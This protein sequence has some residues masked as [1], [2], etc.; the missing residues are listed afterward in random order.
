MKAVIWALRLLLFFVLFGFATKNDH[1]V[2]LHFFFDAHWELPLVF[3]ILLAFIAGTLIG[4]SAALVSWLSHQRE[5]RRLRRELS[6]ERDKR[7]DLAESRSVP[8]TRP[9]S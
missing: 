5:V 2:S 9:P 8:G 6:R 1:T 4:V 7:V 3:V